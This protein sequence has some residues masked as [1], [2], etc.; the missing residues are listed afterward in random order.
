MAGGK[1]ER[2]WPKSRKNLPKQ[3]LNLTGDKSLL[4]QTFIRINK[5]IDKGNIFIV[6]NADYEDLVYTQ[7]PEIP[8]ENIILEPVGRNTA[9]CIGLAAKYI[10]KRDKD[11]T[12]V[13]L[14]SDHL[15]GDE[16]KFLQVL[17]KG[18]EVAEGTNNLVT[19]GIKPN[20]PETGYGYI[21]IGK[22]EIASLQA[23]RNDSGNGIG[24][25]NVERF[26]EKPNFEKAKEYLAS[27]NYF[28]NS[29]MFI[30][31]V[32][33]ILDK[34]KLHLPDLEKGLN[35]IEKDIN[36]P[37]EQETLRKLFPLLPSI[38]VDYGVMEK[39]NNIK[40]IPGDF[41]WDDL[42]SWRALGDILPIKEGNNRVKGEFVQ[43][44][45]K[46]CIV[47]AE[48]KLVAT[49]GVENLVIVQTKDSVLI[50]HK[51]KLEDIKGL[52]SEMQ[53]KGMEKYL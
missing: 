52:I 6:T 3:F 25:Y 24:V 14:P 7:L 21:E 35:L 33:V 42:G 10:Y 23:P 40:V 31:K 18:I 41:G 9:P 4:Q 28:W 20:R 1:G 12:M 50:C 46:D 39:D 30:W 44:A 48:D 8:E 22:D 26:V 17:E 11:A 32:S 37:R 29:G 38:S 34:I 27:G 16:E 51:D 49:V 5:I 45:S 43:V 13:I 15:V 36:S 2:F 47:Y 19:I 53:E